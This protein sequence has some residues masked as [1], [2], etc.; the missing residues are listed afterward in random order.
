MPYVMTQHGSLDNQVT[1]TFFCDEVED[2][3]QI[4][5]KDITFGSVAVVLD[6]MQIFIANSKKEWKSMTPLS[7]EDTTSA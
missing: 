3:A 6:G 4:P 7:D 1:N 2:L 5:S